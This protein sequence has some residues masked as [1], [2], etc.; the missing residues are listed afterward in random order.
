MF[1]NKRFGIS[2]GTAVVF[3]DVYLSCSKQP[4]LKKGKARSRCLECDCNLDLEDN[5]PSISRE[6]SK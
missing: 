2:E 1:D 5:D 4:A 6:V 3:E